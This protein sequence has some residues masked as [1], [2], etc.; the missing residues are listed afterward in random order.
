MSDGQK[1]K[2]KREKKTKE[3]KRNTIRINKNKKSACG[4]KYK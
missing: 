2:E 3:M 4:G 1:T